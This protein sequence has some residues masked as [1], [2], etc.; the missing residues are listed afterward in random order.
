MSALKSLIGK[1]K[2][3]LPGWHAQYLPKA[4]EPHLWR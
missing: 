4:E 3:S 1:G 2:S